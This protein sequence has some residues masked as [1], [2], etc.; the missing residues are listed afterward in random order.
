MPSFA[1]DNPKEIKPILGRTKTSNTPLHIHSKFHVEEGF[2]EY[3]REHL[4]RALDPFT[5]RIERVL[6]HF[7]DIN[8]S[9]RGLD[10][11]CRV[12]VSIGHDEP[13]I[14]EEVG[15]D[16]RVAFDTAVHR[17]ARN[18]QRHIERHWGRHHPRDTLRPV[19]T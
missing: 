9:K 2:R 18:V 1:R 7:E 11:L 8:G 6:V 15:D 17:T 19:G 4:G 16:A 5:N 12:K 10:T 3:I 14:I 13:V